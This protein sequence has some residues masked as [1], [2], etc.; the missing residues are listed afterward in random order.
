MEAE[1]VVVSVRCSRDLASEVAVRDELLEWLR[2]LNLAPWIFTRDVLVEDGA[3]P[4]SHPTLTLNT[5]NRGPFLLASFVHEQLHWYLVERD[6]IADAV[7]EQVLLK[8]YPEVPV[9]LPEGAESEISTYLHLMVCW[10]EVDALRRLLGRDAADALARRLGE[11]G[12]YRWVYRS[13][14]ADYDALEAAFAE[15]GLLPPGMVDA[16]GA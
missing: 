2:R 13:V 6:P 16:G 11:V 7:Y 15:H 1:S 8:R 9:G 4:H 5:F 3:I 10:L 14:L 12:V